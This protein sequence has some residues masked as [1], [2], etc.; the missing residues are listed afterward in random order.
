MKTNSIY[1]NLRLDAHNKKEKR[2]SKIKK[3]NSNSNE[4]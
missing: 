1:T 4:K 3:D 2:K